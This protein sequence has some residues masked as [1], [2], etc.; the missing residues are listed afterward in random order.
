MTRLKIKHIT[1]IE[2]EKY[3]GH[4]KDIRMITPNYQKEMVT[5]YLA[6]IID[7]NENNELR[8][9]DFLSRE[10]AQKWINNIKEYSSLS[11]DEVLNKLAES[12]RNLEEKPMPEAEKPSNAEI[13]RS[14]SPY[15][16]KRLYEYPLKL[17]KEKYP[18]LNYVYS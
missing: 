14:T 10:E 13:W 15:V 18:E 5:L 1:L 6:G 8:P 9:Y 7:V 3:R 11:P 4:I 2:W 12:I 16:N 17:D